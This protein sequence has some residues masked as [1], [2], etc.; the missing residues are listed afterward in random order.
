[1]INN[2]SPAF[3]GKVLTQ[4]WHAVKQLNP[5]NV[6][7]EARKP[8]RIGIISPVE[9]LQEVAAA[10]VGGNPRDFERA[11]DVLMLTP[12][13]L[14]RTAYPVLAGCDFIIRS[15]DS[16]EGLPGVPS[17]RIF[18]IAS[19]DDLPAAIKEI[20]RSLNWHIRT[21]RSPGRCPD[22]APR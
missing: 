10:L 18:T 7:A 17:T 8:V 22:C 21:F 11:E 3:K 2:S 6:A 15:T 14:D 13:P 1:M 19:K 12:T 16:K 4:V 5:E 20:L 9:M